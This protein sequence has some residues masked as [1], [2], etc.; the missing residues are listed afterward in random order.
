MGEI[1]RLGFVGYGAM[2]QK[3]AGR[4]RAAGSSVAAFDP[5]QQGDELDGVRLVDSAASLAR[6]VD[7]VLVAVPADAALERSTEG[8]GGVLE[9]ASTGLL[10]IDF[11]TVSPGASRRLAERAA[12]AGVRFVEAPMSG[13][14]PEAAAGQ[15]VILAGGAAE[16]VQAASPILEVVG[17]RT[18]HAGPV[19]S[20]LAMKLAVNGVMA[21]GMAALAEALAYGVGSGLDR[22]VLIDL[23]RDLALVSDHHKRKLAMA[24]ERS[25]PSEFPTRLMAKD[26]GLLLADAG[27][28]G[29][30]VASMAAAAQLFSFAAVGHGDE[31]YAS[32]VETMERLAPAP[33]QGS[34][35]GNAGENR[36]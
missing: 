15:L 34:K 12:S 23:F 9:G 18:I 22:D 24:K 16:D 4:L 3:M 28:L 25:F 21:L 20:G 33:G 31:D 1:R 30:P 6:Q 11:S 13:S 26:M 2:A 27:R 10:L 35:P 14:T 29:V 7:A 5:G 36:S 17:R 8:P 19:G 32:A